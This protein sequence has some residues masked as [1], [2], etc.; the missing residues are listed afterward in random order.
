MT[1][2]A[3]LK[4]AEAAATFPGLANAAADQWGG[5]AMNEERAV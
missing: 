1:A 5:H 2:P 3:L 4:P